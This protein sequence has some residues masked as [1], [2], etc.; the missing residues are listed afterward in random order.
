[1]KLENDDIFKGYI[2]FYK[3]GIP[4][5]NIRQRMRNEGHFDP[6]MMDQFAAPNHVEEAD[7]MLI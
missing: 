6:K 1:M 3:M 7:A 5:A 4:L 2:K